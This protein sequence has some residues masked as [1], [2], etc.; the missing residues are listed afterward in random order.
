MRNKWSESAREKKRQCFLSWNVVDESESLSLLL[1][2]WRLAG[3]WGRGVR[4]VTDKQPIIVEFTCE[5]EK[6][7]VSLSKLLS[8]E[9]L[10]SWCRLHIGWLQFFQEFPWDLGSFVTERQQVKVFVPFSPM[11]GSYSLSAESNN[12]VKVLKKQF[13]ILWLSRGVGAFECLFRR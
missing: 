11:I 3:G 13:C 2:G 6:R 5:C 10:S 12:T 8:D 7:S 1:L 4:V 9:L